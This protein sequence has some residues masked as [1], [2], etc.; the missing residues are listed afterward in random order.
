[1]RPAFARTAALAAALLL[2]ACRARPPKYDPI[3]LPN[4]VEVR[5]LVV[6]EK[7]S[8]VR[9]GQEIEIHYRGWLAS[10]EEF[11]SS[12][13]RG[14]PIRFRLGDGSVPRGLEQG[15]DGML[16]FGRRRIAVPPELGY[17]AEGRPPHVPPDAA[18]VFEVELLAIAD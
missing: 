10:G 8:A 16:L 5:D 6:P 18:L 14:E 4:G 17:G 11:D 2:A 9:A 12:V 7:G 13:E 1:M 15:I 3:L